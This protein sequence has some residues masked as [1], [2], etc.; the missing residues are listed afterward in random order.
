MYKVNTFTNKNG[1]K[2]GGSAVTENSYDLA[3]I[4]VDTIYDTDY[5]AATAVKNALAV[6]EECDHEMKFDSVDMYQD[7]WATM[8][9]VNVYR[10]LKCD[11]L[12]YWKVDDDAD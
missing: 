9:D 8:H 6:I 10:C 4:Y 7:E 2:W 5:E 3:V 12:T 1:S 11:C